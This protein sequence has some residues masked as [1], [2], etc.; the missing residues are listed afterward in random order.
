MFL[1]FLPL[2]LV[3]VEARDKQQGVPQVVERWGDPHSSEFVTAVSMIVRNSYPCHFVAL[4]NLYAGK[5][6]GCFLGKCSG[7]IRSIVRELPDLDSYLRIWDTNTR[8]LLSVVGFV[9][10]FFVHGRILYEGLE[11]KMMW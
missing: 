9:P 8:Q 2:V 11:T 1:I 6:L 5:M 7:S 3:I 4:C 10:C